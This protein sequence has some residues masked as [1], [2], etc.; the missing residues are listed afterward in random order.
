MRILEKPTKESARLGIEDNK[1]YHFI[2]NM[3][4]KCGDCKIDD[5]HIKGL[6]E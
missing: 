4:V 2:S 3:W 5:D 6:L 1:V